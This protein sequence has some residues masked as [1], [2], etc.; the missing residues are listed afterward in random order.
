[1][2]RRIQRQSLNSDLHS[3]AKALNLGVT[4]SSAQQQMLLTDK[5]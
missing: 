5:I 4:A 1:M 2:R 3:L